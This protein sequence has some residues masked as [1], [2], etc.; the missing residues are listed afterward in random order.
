[1]H[2]RYRVTA[3]AFLSLSA[4]T[5]WVNSA[6]ADAAAP[7]KIDPRLLGLPALE[8]PAPFVPKVTAPKP[9][10]PISAEPSTTPAP[11]TAQTPAKPVEAPAPAVA[12][13][14]VRTPKVAAPSKPAPREHD[15]KP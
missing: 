4:G 12:Q 9:A 6:R 13:E 1:M 15:K 8:E 3:L 7:L 11:I 10:A 2:P 5:L 14:P